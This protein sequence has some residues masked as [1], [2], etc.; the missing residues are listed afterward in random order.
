MFLQKNIILDTDI[1]NEIDDQFALA[2]IVKS[3]FSENLS[4]ITLAPYDPFWHDYTIDKVMDKNIDVA[5]NLLKILKFKNNLTYAGC[6]NFLYKNV[7]VEN[8]AVD[9][10]I[11]IA[12]K[13]KVTIISIAALT[14]IAA[15]LIRKPEIL[16]LIHI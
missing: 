9:K 2:Y 15:A 3:K 8:E 16:S 10:I 13:D 14:N 6:S 4:A 11:E 5:N 12:S 1:S 7:L